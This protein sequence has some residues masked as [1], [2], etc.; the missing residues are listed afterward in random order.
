MPTNRRRR[1]QERVDVLTDAQRSHLECGCYFF[2][3]QGEREHFRDEAHRQRT[4]ALYPIP[5][6]D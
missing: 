1:V 4:W 6:H 3:W 5:D 2:D